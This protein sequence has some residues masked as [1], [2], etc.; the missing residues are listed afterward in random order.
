MNGS[1]PTERVP[2]H[3]PGQPRGTSGTALGHRLHPYLCA[4]VW[5]VSLLASCLPAGAQASLR[6]IGEMEI[7]RRV[8]SR[9]LLRHKAQADS[10]LPDL[11][12]LLL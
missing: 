5:A 3:P 8:R 1:V 9:A 12:A 7:G 2:V 11:W 10:R 6:K 4:S